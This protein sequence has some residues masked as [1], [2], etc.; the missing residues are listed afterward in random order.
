MRRP[1]SSWITWIV[2]S[3][4]ALAVATWGCQGGTD[5]RLLGGSDTT[6][7]TAAPD[8][9]TG[10][11]GLGDEYFPYAG[12]G[13]YD[14]LSYTITLTCDPATGRLAGTTVVKAEALQ[15][16]N[17]MNLDF[18]GLEISRL[19][20][21]GT[22]ATYERQAH[23][24]VVECPQPLK[25]GQIFSVAV[26][27]SGKPVGLTS[28]DGY[29]EG[30]QWVDDTIFTLDEPEGAA[31]WFPLNDHPS[32][33]AT[34]EFNLTVPAQYTATANG[35]LVEV[36]EQGGEKTFVWR[37]DQPMAN[38]LAAVA[39]GEFV[40]QE[41]ASPAGVPIRNYFD[42]AVAEQGREAFARTGEVL[43]YFSALF[44][45]YPFDVYGVVVPDATVGAAMENQTISLFGRDVVEQ[46]MT[47][48]VVGQMFLSHELSHQWFGDSVTLAEWQDIWIN[49]GFATY[50]SWLWAEHDMGQEG[51]DI[52]VQW[53]LESLASADETPTGDPGV[54]D[55][56]GASVYERGGLTM[57]ALRLT[58]GDELFFGILR[59][60]VGRYAYGIAT[61]EDFI[62]LVKQ[63]AGHLQGVD[64]DAFFQGWLYDEKM[65]ALPE[66]A[67]TG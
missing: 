22:P 9:A 67:V 65:P 49:E 32:D 53:A 40:L 4:L 3:L 37:M 60:W 2:G 64:L 66:A 18:S 41:T 51:M 56:F 25:T 57:H 44:G 20:V 7:T 31:T 61:T 33:K 62:A 36:K 13:G 34:Y 58:L 55:L 6:G 27:Y 42:V 45:P 46:T 39:V 47:D 10:S 12:N 16:L 5:E 52:W 26:T 1:S 43:D 8:D 63:K 29:P 23:E 28:A 19:E 48:P 50:A 21:D 38:Y 35:L 30:W 11:A 24:L 14:A 54:K 15:A 59:D 17:T